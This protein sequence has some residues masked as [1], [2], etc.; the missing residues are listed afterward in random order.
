MKTL[1]LRTTAGGRFDAAELLKALDAHGPF[2][3]RTDYTITL[4]VTPGAADSF[5]EPKAPA[6]PP[7][8]T[9]D[10]SADAPDAGPD[11]SAD[12]AASE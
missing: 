11:A 3:P 5:S 8:D 12:P 10:A 1:T 6:A 9:A 4:D 2:E 7:V